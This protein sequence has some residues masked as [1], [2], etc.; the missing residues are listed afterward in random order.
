MVV[1]L[2]EKIESEPRFLGNLWMSDEAHFHLHGKVNSKNNVYW[3]T[4]KP[5]EVAQK[6][7]HSE[8][9]TVWIAISKR[10][11]IRPFFFEEE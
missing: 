4:E 2:L 9:C 7:L 10:G 1:K 3:G 11:L 8:K 6:P 5:I